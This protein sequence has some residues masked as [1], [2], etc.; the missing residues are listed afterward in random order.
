MR[1]LRGIGMILLALAL[2]HVP[3]AHATLGPVEVIGSGER[4]M[5]LVPGLACD[6]SVWRSFAERQSERFTLH[7][8]T[9]AGFAGAPAP[10]EPGSDEGTPWLDGAVRD[11]A[12]YI[13][14][15]Q[16]AGSI[17]VGHS[18][19]GLVAYRLAIEHPDL[20]AGAVAI[21]AP[22][23]VPIGD[24]R[25][26][27]E[28]RLELVRGVLAPALRAQSNDAW[29]A[30]QRSSWMAMVGD[31]AR[32][33]ALL[34]TSLK[35]PRSVS[36]RYALEMFKTDLRGPLE[37]V[38]VPVLA[39]AALPD[40]EPNADAI[41][42]VWAEQLAPAERVS[43]RFVEDSRHFIMDDQPEALDETIGA[44]IAELDA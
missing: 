22:P 10:Q 28:E 43:L 33:E 37:G 35:T 5:V 9:L 39:V 17:V 23:A 12:A 44:F 3:R 38:R 13:R 14:D 16:L 26:E 21:D 11:V 15:E 19:G 32:G 27:P 36:E 30:Q 4:A 20:I 18:L 8:I 25:L 34:E 2:V 29:L 42:A 24:R 7:A 1:Q 6:S 31:S 41:R 40:D